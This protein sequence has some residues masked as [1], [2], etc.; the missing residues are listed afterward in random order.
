M[1]ESFGIDSTWFSWRKF[2]WQWQTESDTEIETETDSNYSESDCD[3]DVQIN[4]HNLHITNTDNSTEKKDDWIQVLDRD[5]DQDNSPT[6]FPPVS[7]PGPVNC[8]PEDSLPHPFVWR[9]FCRLISERNQYL[10]YMETTRFRQ[11]V[12]QANTKK[13]SFS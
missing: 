5:A 9:G 13:L 10:R 2:F 11:K 12:I 8:I 4:L 1:A 6:V 7:P 3:E